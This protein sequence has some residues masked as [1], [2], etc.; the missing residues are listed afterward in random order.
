MKKIFT[1]IAVMTIG[2]L[3]QSTA[4]LAQATTAPQTTTSPI[5]LDEKTQKK[6]DKATADLAKDQ[7]KLTK[8]TASY[9]KEKAKFEKDQSKGK[10]SPDKIAKG[11]KSLEQAENEMGK[12]K[13]IIA[14]NQALI[15]KYN[16]AKPKM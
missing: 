11:K 5:Q 1:I 6:V 4:L 7:E 3:L 9:E 8:V 13:K 16:P 10:L 2:F 14:D 15:N 12:L